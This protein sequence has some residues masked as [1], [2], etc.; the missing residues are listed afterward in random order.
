MYIGTLVTNDNSVS[1]EIEA[2]IAADIR[3]YYE[4]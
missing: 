3:A 4:L 2:W 1:K